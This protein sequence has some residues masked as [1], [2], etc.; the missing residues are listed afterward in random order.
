MKTLIMKLGMRYDENSKLQHAAL[1]EVDQI[2]NMFKKI[3]H[4]TKIIQE[5]SDMFKSIQEPSDM[6]IKSDMLVIINGLVKPDMDEFNKMQYDFIDKFDGPVFFCYC[7]IGL[8]LKRYS[9]IR[10]DIICITQ[11]LNTMALLSYTKTQGN[12]E[13][14]E[15]WHFP[16]YKFPIMTNDLRD[17]EIR[18][19]DLLYGGGFRNGERESDMIEFYFNKPVL[20]VGLF[21]NITEK[22]FLKPYDTAPMFLK[23]VDYSDMC[24][25]MSKSFATVIISDPIYKEM[26]S[27]TQRI[28]ESILA[29]CVTF[30]HEK[31]DPLHFV[32]GKNA[33]SKLLYVN[34]GAELQQKI[35]SLKNNKSLCNYIRA[36][37]KDKTQISF[38]NMLRLDYIN[39][40]STFITRRLNKE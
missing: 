33:L 9:I 15:I 39:K 1:G 36:H 22:M 24:N 11:A 35:I 30:I 29:G 34:T 6:S 12:Y 25:M 14:T 32:Y 27:L 3:G 13:F 7:D 21:G 40:F 38:L 23:S 5:P 2:T 18:D 4:D 28:Y 20:N 37:A 19:F 26:Y 8:P 10:N 16:F 31:V 17:N